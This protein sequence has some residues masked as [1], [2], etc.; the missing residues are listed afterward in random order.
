[1]QRGRSG[2]YI[3]SAAKEMNSGQPRTNPVSIKVKGLNLEPRLLN[4]HPIHSAILRLIRF[5]SVC[6]STNQFAQGMQLPIDLTPES[7]I[8]DSHNGGQRETP[9]SSCMKTRSERPRYRVASLFVCNG[10]YFE[11]NF[12]VQHF[13][14]K[15]IYLAL[16][17]LEENLRREKSQSL[18]FGL[19]AVET[20]E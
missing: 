15:T 6:C 11:Y 16:L 4:Q 18:N 19:N 8:H 20:R 1:M 2:G 13:L 5:V 10:E 9:G 7:Y 3:R 14:Q 12:Q 17:F